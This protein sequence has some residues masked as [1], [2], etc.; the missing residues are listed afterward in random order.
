MSR[1]NR[2]PEEKERR[3]K[4]PDGRQPTENAVSGYD[5]YY[6]EMDG[7]TAELERDPRTT[8]CILC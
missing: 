7:K 3:A 8:G 4:I 6:E 5:G 1:K 2:T